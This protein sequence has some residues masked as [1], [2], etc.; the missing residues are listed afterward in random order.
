MEIKTIEDLIQVLKSKEL[1]GV[2]D[3]YAIGTKDEN[4]FRYPN[5]L[6]FLWIVRLYF[7]EF[8]EIPNSL[9][10]HNPWV[11]GCNDL[12]YDSVKNGIYVRRGEFKEKIWLKNNS[13][14]IS[15]LFGKNEYLFS[16]KDEAYRFLEHY[17]ENHIDEALSIIERRI[18]ECQRII[19]KNEK[20]F[21]EL[22]TKKEKMIKSKFKLYDARKIKRTSSCNIGIF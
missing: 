16:G 12:F 17:T 18:K 15:L 20:R 13:N 4:V 5:A 6:G 3:P 14:G 10:P 22:K 11:E 2:G 7:D 1:F 8:G 19:K 9:Y 21:K